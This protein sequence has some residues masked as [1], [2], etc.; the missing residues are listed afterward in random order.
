MILPNITY[1]ITEPY[2][3]FPKLD[4]NNALYSN[5]GPIA[6]NVLNSIAS[7]K[8]DRCVG[9]EGLLLFASSKLFNQPIHFFEPKILG[10][11]GF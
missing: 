10:R 9:V 3:L 4:E 11:Y 2:N 5:S 7:A 1:D 6:S 8:S